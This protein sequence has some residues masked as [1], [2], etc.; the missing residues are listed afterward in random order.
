MNS[1]ISVWKICQ[2]SSQFL[3]TKPGVELQ[4]VNRHLANISEPV[5]IRENKT[6]RSNIYVA[7]MPMLSVCKHLNTTVSKSESFSKIEITL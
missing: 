1:A 6:E 2:T 4:L 3:I 5:W 7:F